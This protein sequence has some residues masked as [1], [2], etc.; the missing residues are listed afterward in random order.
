MIDS[1]T[2]TSLPYL[3]YNIKIVKDTNPIIRN[4]HAKTHND[5]E[6]ILAITIQNNFFVFCI[7]RYILYFFN[8]I[9]E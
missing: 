8:F 7:F 5:K 6:G 9:N 1:R 3:V 4:N 2:D